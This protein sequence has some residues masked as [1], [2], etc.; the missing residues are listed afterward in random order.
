MKINSCNGQPFWISVA[1]Y[2]Y[3]VYI[4]ANC[5]L[6]RG[7]GGWEGSFRHKYPFS[8]I[9]KETMDRPQCIDCFPSTYM[10]SCTYYVITDGGGGPSK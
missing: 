3:S 9:A 7:G 6:L 2:T 1:T 5:V 10:G 8:Y 4:Q